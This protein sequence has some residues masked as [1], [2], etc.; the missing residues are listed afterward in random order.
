MRK[1]LLVIAVLLGVTAW[2]VSSA[3]AANVHFKG[4]GGPSF[5]DSGIALTAA[6]TV[7]GLGNQGILL[8]LSATAQPVATCTNPAG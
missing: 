5:T 6:R 8:T 4:K 1:L 7:A 3:A 2:S